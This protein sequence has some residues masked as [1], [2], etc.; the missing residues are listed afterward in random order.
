[1][2]QSAGHNRTQLGGPDAPLTAEESIPAVVDVLEAQN[3]VTVRRGLTE[4]GQ[5][6]W[7]RARPGLALAALG[8]ALYA[9][10]LWR[11]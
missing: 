8:F 3:L 7:L 6:L 11:A 9:L 1:M 2:G 5:L 10:A 4:T